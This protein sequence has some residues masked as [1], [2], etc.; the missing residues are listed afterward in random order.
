[1]NAR[2]SG[3]DGIAEVLVVEDD[4]GDAFLAQEYIR[5]QS[6]DSVR[7]IHAS[8]LHEALQAL[9]AATSCVLLDLNLPDAEGTAALDAIREAAPSVPVVVLT[10]QQGRVAGVAALNAGAQDYLEKNELSSSTLWRSIRFAVERQQSTARGLALLSAALR[11]DENS[12]LT[13]GLIPTPQLRA[14]DLEWA[15]KYSPASQQALLG[16]DFIDAIE[17]ADGSIRLVIGDVSGH[18]PEE[19]ALGAAMRIGWRALVL[20]GADQPDALSS[21]DELFVAERNSSTLFTSL[22]DVRV[23]ADRRTT[24]VLSAG[25][26]APLLIEAGQISQLEVEAGPVLG[27]GLGVGVP[28]TIRLPEQWR[29]LLFTDGIFEGRSSDGGRLGVPAF[30]ELA[31]THLGTTASHEGLGKLLDAVEFEHGGALPDDVAMFLI[32]RRGPG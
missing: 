31:A 7:T 19:A 22:C 16:G 21:L 17:L 2:L 18:G 9:S 25:H 11:R 4:A 29:L 8:T 20:A 23:G 6:D 1:V 3:L 27:L 10:G 13:R 28:T 12:R 5:D 24:T 26:E 15:S 14:G 32:A 30:I